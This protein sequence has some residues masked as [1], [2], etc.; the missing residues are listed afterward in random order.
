MSAARSR[1]AAIAAG[2][3]PCASSDDPYAAAAR[4][5]IAR[6]LG[7]A[8]QLVPEARLLVAGL[9]GP[10]QRGIELRHQ[11]LGERQQAGQSFRLK[12]IAASL[13]MMSVRVGS[14]SSASPYISS[15][16]LSSSSW[17]AQISAAS[18]RIR[19]RS[20]TSGNGGRRP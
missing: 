14:S 15:A 2:P 18:T 5:Q 3:S 1:R 10:A 12:R 7:G 17:L 11:V 19:T 4:A 16:W 6:L 9:F 20:S 13:S 8:R